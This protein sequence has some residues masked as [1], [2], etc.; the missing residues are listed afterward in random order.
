MS[1]E[2]AAD[3]GAVSYGTANNLHL[4]AYNPNAIVDES[5][6]ITLRLTCEDKEREISVSNMASEAAVRAQVPMEWFS[7]GVHWEDIALSQKDTSTTQLLTFEVSPSS[8]VNS[9]YNELYIHENTSFIEYMSRLKIAI[10][11]SSCFDTDIKLARGKIQTPL[12]SVSLNRTLQIPNDGKD[13]KLPDDLGRFP[14]FAVK[15]FE[16]NVPPHWLSQVCYILASISPSTILIFGKHST[17]V[18]QMKQESKS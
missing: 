5:K 4:H 9:F 13:H 3:S 8:D 6:L 18:T 2:G 15:D 12:F 17:R 16:Q 14:I 11:C 10:G 7:D 1:R